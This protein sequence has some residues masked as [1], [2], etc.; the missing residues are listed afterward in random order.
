MALPDELIEQAARAVSPILPDRPRLV[1]NGS[2]VVLAA[3]NDVATT[4]AI[5]EP[6][7]EDRP[8]AMPNL[9]ES[10]WL[11]RPSLVHIRQAAHSRNRSA[12][13]VLH[14]VLARV[15]ALVSP[16]VVLP[17]IVGDEGSLNYFAAIVGPSGAGKSTAVGIGQAL[18]PGDDK[19]IDGRP[20]GTGEGLAE[21]YMGT[22][23][24]IDPSGKMIKVRRQVADRAFVYVDEGEVLFNMG[25]RKGTTILEA[26]RRA[27]SG[28][29]LGQSNGTSERTRVIPRHRYRLSLV[30]GFQPDR[31]GRLLADGAGGT[32]QRFTWASA[33]DPS[34]PD[35][36]PA[37]PGDLE[38]LAVPFGRHVIDVHPTIAAQ[39]R[40]K[41]LARVRGDEVAQVLD[42]HAD[43][44]RLK[45]AALLGILDGRLE[46]TLSDWDLA[47]RVWSMS[48]R[49]R[50]AVLD[51]V[52]ADAARTE[53]Q[54]LDRYARRELA[55]E[56]ARSSADVVVQRLAARV[57]RWM[58]EHPQDG[59]RPKRDLLNRLKDTERS[60][61]T[62]VV[63]HAIGQGWVT[64]Q[65]GRFDVGSSR[66]AA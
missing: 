23:D 41:D 8:P 49:V 63:A 40:T 12:D 36:A 64:E 11:A 57:A 16:D 1:A 28:S 24:D 32:P 60:M 6:T 52:A 10:F 9:G 37:W 31:A 34:V 33:I 14:V 61:F 30:I 47:D 45:I 58:H 7:A 59:G 44:Y 21:L 55:G 25:D 39:I 29:A 65:E 3:V 42:S 51:N 56:V 54:A 20:I 2:G 53:A 13:A 17:A 26:L 5:P 38:V 48:V 46:V 50:Q 35:T 43:L 66:P 18:V 27:W 62:A 15:A 19:L 22:E 4:V